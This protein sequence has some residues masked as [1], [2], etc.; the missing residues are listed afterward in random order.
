MRKE[1]QVHYYTFLFDYFII[2]VYE[3]IFTSAYTP[4]SAHHRRSRS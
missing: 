1:L 2:F 4:A 3:Y